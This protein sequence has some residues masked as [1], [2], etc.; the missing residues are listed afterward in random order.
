LPSDGDLVIAADGGYD[1]L[2]SLGITPNIIIGDLDSVRSEL[3]KEIE[4]IRHKVEK[5]ETDTHLAYLEGAR[6]GYTEFE[7]YGGTGG[8]EDH[9]F[10]NYSL[11]LY[12]KNEGNNIKL[13]SENMDVFVIKNEKIELDGKA[14]G[15]FSAFAI[16]GVCRGV[17]IDGLY[18][19]AW[20]VTLTPEFPIGVS[21]H[22]VGKRATV[23]VRSGTLL[24][25]VE[26]V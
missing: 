7:L 10:A 8:R 25:M 5:D 20:D 11:L 14:D 9:T 6:R 23:E 15:G 13:V 12:A 24:I 22:F 17:T 18:Y 19:N 16:G 2:L 3:P 21:N 1:N 26:R 4:L